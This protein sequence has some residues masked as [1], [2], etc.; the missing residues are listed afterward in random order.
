MNH[1]QYSLQIKKADNL[2]TLKA[3][4]KYIREMQVLLLKSGGYWRA[5]SA[6][7]IEP[8]QRIYKCITK[9]LAMYNGAK[10]LPLFIPE[11]VTRTEE[12]LFKYY[13]S[14]GT[15][16]ETIIDTFQFV[17]EVSMRNGS[18]DLIKPFS[19]IIR[20]N[21]LPFKVNYHIGALPNYRYV[22]HEVN[23][24][25][26]RISVPG[27][28]YNSSAETIVLQVE[29]IKRSLPASIK[30]TVLETIL[31]TLYTYLHV[32][33]SFNTED[34]ARAVTATENM[35]TVVRTLN[36][37]INSQQSYPKE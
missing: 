19:L 30:Y 26:R 12:W 33:T 7:T 13:C 1:F 25:T 36:T 29:E 4:E 37:R 14:N 17:K 23:Q 28:T 34:S 5:T 11:A 22:F 9:A 10:A 31:D 21:P 27:I 32:S 2:K 6:D 16:Y 18:E 8:V 15:D 3:K 35:L 24:R 20:D